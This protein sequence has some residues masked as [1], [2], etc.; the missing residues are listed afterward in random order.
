MPVE[1]DGLEPSIGARALVKGRPPRGLVG[2]I[3]LWHTSDIG[4]DTAT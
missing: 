2:S 4:L 1:N 3:Q